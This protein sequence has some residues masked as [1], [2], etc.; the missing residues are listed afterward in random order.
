MTILIKMNK[1]NEIFYTDD[2]VTLNVYNKYNIR[3]TWNN[4]IC[5][6]ERT[7]SLIHTYFL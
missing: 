3:K 4:R 2:L 1:E 5:Q 7:Y 6:D